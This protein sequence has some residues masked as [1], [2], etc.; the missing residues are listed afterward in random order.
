MKFAAHHV[1][2]TRENYFSEMLRPSPDY[3]PTCA[4]PEDC[5]VQWGH[6]IIPAVPFFEAFPPGT[7]IRGEG[8]DIAQAEQS[9]FAQYQ[10]DLACDHQWGRQHP[11]PRGTL[12]T[13]GAGWCRKC[14]A[15]RGKMFK[16]I[17]ELGGWRKPLSRSEFWVIEEEPD[18]EFDAYF[19]RKFPA[20]AEA[21]RRYKRV[22]QMRFKL[23]GASA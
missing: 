16:P 19:D 7:F 15:F 12:Y 5:T 4:W 13:N 22:L 8:A 14:G 1:K 3:T 9:A 20:D 18:P 10:R 21:S 23:F 11:G 17:V 6:G 2:G